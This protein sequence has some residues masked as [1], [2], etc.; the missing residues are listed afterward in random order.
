MSDSEIV[1]I[2]DGSGE[3]KLK[4]KKVTYEEV[5]PSTTCLKLRIEKK[6]RGGK[7][8][9]VVYD[10]PNN[11]PYFKKMLKEL[12]GFCGTGGSQKKNTLEIQGDN[13]EKTRDFFEKKGFNVKGS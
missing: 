7:S 9:T 5:T 6:G 12:K 1:Y 2:C 4:K 11:P 10:L 8:V 3:N 13:I